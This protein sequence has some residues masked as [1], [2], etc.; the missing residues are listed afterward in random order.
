MTEK[1][2][3]EA[4]RDVP[5]ADEA[6]RAAAH[7]HWARL[8]KPLG[9]LGALETLVE[10]AAALTGRETPDVSR[11]AALVLC[12]DNGVVAQGVSQTDQSVTRAVAAN[13]AAGRTSVCRMAAAARC[14]VVPVDIGMAGEKVEG[15][16]DRRIADGT[17]DFT[18]GP[19][20]TRE[21]ALSAIETGMALVRDAREAGFS[22]LAT[23]EMG[24]G[25]TT[26]SSAVAAVLLGEPVERM[27]GRGAGLSDAGLGRKLDA[28]RRGIS[29]NCPN[30]EDALDVLGKL[31]G[32]DIAGLCGVFL[33]GARYRVPI[34]MDGFISGVAALCAV[35]LCPNAEAAIFASHASSEPAAR[36]VMEALGKRPLI[37]AGMHLGEGT[38]AV[39]SIPLWDMALA[40]YQGCYSFA[41]GGIAPYTP[42]C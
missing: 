22:L 5:G 1:E 20:M 37:T 39:A 18:Q 35:R 13:L 10:D 25:N 17:A 32:L 9:G 3:K 14:D 34:V 21:Q 4:L 23:G 12:A 19:A 31:G 26:T 27:T 7:A 33:G 6:A 2:L 30:A 29:R 40:V 11:R 41:E 16:L 8:A 36:R 38:G 24:I 15:V 28:I 42:Q